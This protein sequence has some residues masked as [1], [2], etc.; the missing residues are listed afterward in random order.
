MAAT[1]NQEE[2]SL[3]IKIIKTND[4][5][6]PYDLVVTAG[7]GNIGHPTEMRSSIE[8]K[9]DMPK[10]MGML[11]TQLYSKISVNSDKVVDLDNRPIDPVKSKIQQQREDADVMIKKIKKVQ[12]VHIE[13]TKARPD[14]GFDKMIRMSNGKENP[15]LIVSVLSNDL[16][17]HKNAM[18]ATH[19]LGQM[20]KKQQEAEDEEAAR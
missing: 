16:E 12:N 13:I 10:R 5:K 18:I 17:V 15:T 7:G 6:Q 14:T 8:K 3:N 9:E 11:L 2:V 20:L 4:D 19:G 1:L